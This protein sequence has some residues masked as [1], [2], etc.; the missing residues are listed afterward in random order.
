[1]SCPTSPL[2]SQVHTA[3]ALDHDTLATPRDYESL[4]QTILNALKRSV[5]FA[6]VSSVCV[7]GVYVCARVHMCVCVYLYV[8]GLCM[9]TSV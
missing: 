8:C 4:E 6:R 5:T 3:Y 2:P 7:G 9:L 1:M